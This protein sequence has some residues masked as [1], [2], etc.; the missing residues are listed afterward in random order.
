MIWQILGVASLFFNSENA[1]KLVGT[2]S[3]LISINKTHITP[4]TTNTSKNI[5]MNSRLN[6]STNLF[7]KNRERPGIEKIIVD[8][9]PT[10]N[11]VKSKKFK[12]N[13]KI[14]KVDIITYRIFFNGSIEKHIP[15]V[16]AD[17][18]EN[19]YKYAYINKK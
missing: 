4:N 9:I 18:Q 13:E 11:F 10:D 1:D 12:T 2:N 19:R 3:E 14:R 6:Q 8:T 7:F 15:K 5:I 16:I 17:G